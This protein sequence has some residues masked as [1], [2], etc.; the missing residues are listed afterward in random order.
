MGGKVGGA[1]HRNELEI[2]YVSH[3]A[4][5]DVEQASSIRFRERGRLHFR[6]LLGNRG[7]MKYIL[8]KLGECQDLLSKDSY[9]MPLQIYRKAQTTNKRRTK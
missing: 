2:I 3:E 7:W 6:K 5:W 9:N 4:L 1:Q 8:T